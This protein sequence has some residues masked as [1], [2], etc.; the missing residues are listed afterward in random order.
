MVVIC[1][2][3]VTIQGHYGGDPRPLPGLPPRWSV[4]TVCYV[5]SKIGQTTCDVASDACHLG[6][7]IWAASGTSCCSKSPRPAPS[8]WPRPTGPVWPGV[9]ATF[10]RCKTRA[11]VSAAWAPGAARTATSPHG[12][13]WLASLC[14]AQLWL[15]PLDSKPPAKNHK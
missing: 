15:G 12:N 11:P 4:Q 1:K 8:R 2:N 5:Q 13:P 6:R 9:P 7:H 3:K 14:P 10:G